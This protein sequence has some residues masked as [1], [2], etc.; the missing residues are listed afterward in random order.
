MVL[1][2]II[3]LIPFLCFQYAVNSEQILLCIE[4]KWT[5]SVHIEGTPHHVQEIKHLL[6]G[7]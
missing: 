7:G 1:Y 4:L 5:R 2:G 3:V 6:F